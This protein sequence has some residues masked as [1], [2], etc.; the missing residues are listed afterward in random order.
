ME[1]TRGT[2]TGHFLYHGL[3]RAS[4]LLRACDA[5]QEGLCIFLRTVKL[6]HGQNEQHVV[7]RAVVHPREQRIRPLCVYLLAP[8]RDTVFCVE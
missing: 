6:L 4:H 7:I 3:F 8:R 1:S 5:L 2:I